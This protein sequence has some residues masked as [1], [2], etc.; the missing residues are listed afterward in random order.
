MFHMQI[1]IFSTYIILICQSHLDGIDIPAWLS[2]T[3]S[4]LQL[5]HVHTVSVLVSKILPDQ[6]W[7]KNAWSIQA[8]E[9]DDQRFY[10]SRNIYSSCLHASIYIKL[11]TNFH[12]PIVCKEVM[13]TALP[14]YLRL[15]CILIA[16]S[17]SNC[18]GVL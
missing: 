1:Y 6:E 3:N 9:L 16:D 11:S 14:W 13:R 8:H 12:W 7:I 10:L 18:N 5:T 17:E 4:M 2:F 15:W